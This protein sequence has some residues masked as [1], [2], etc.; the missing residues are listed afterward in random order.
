MAYQ[1]R[2]KLPPLR[3]TQRCGDPVDVRSIHPGTCGKQS[4]PPPEQQDQS[5]CHDALVSENEDTSL[6]TLHDLQSQ[7]A[8]EGWNKIRGQVLLTAVEMS[9][10]P[11][12]QTGL[13][14]SEKAILRCQK[15]GPLVHYCYQCY[16]KQHE[17]AN[18]FDVPE[19]I[20]FPLFNYFFKNV[21]IA[22]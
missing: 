14:C 5:P 1:K 9:A 16:L 19:K 21:F 6:P 12:G 13:C 20:L 15:C 4:V 18:F 3:L 8:V 22:C 11:E 17:R 7:A 10:M 2:Y